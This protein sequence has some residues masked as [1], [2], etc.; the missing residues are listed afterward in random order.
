M[1]WKNG[2]GTTTQIHVAGDDPVQFD[3]RVSI[4]TVAGD[5]PFSRFPGYDRHIMMIDGGG[6]TLAGGPDGDIIVSPAF[7]PRSFPG[8]W[9]VH[10]KLKSGPSRD[11]N[12][13]VRRDKF[14][15]GLKAMVTEAQTFE[16]QTGWLLLH[17][18]EGGAAAADLALQHGDSLLLNPGETIPVVATTG[19]LRLVVCK[20]WP[21]RS[22]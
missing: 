18:F 4:A 10:G 5:G 2:G 21:R 16:A 12:L 9:D 1:P 8:D 19:K 17:L 14:A 11:F 3:W 13:I 22:Q 6:M 20:V 7:V 15:S